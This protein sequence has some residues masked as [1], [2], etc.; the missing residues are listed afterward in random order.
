MTV[1]IQKKCMCF[2]LLYF[3]VIDFSICWYCIWVM[4][5][6]YRNSMGKCASNVTTSSSSSIG[7]YNASFLFTNLSE[8]WTEIL[9]LGGDASPWQIF[10]SKNQLKDR[11]WQKWLRNGMR[12]RTAMNVRY[13]VTNQD[14][15]LEWNHYISLLLLFLSRFSSWLANRLHRPFHLC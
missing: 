2:F 3:I 8:I 13:L 14:R 11:R 4:I 12:M 7:S 1:R 5:V 9:M 10:I 15:W 6:C